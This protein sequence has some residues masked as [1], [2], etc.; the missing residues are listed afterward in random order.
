MECRQIMS[1]S[2]A[3]AQQVPQEEQRTYWRGRGVVCSSSRS[4]WHNHVKVNPVRQNRERQNGR[5]RKEEKEYREIQPEH[6]GVHRDKGKKK[7]KKRRK[8]RCRTGLKKRK[9][10]NTNNTQDRRDIC[11]AMNRNR[12]TDKTSRIRFPRRRQR[13]ANCPGRDIHC[14]KL[15]VA[16]F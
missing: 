8:S 6:P 15:G 2:T 4:V 13:D 12:N 7:K 10:I 3:F 14:P 11:H 5:P 16:M 1:M 9:G